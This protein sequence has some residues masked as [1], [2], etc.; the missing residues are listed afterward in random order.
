MLGDIV[1]K[2]GCDGLIS[3]LP[4]LREEHSPDLIIANGENAASGLGITISITRRLLMAG[5]HVITLGNHTWHR[6]EIIP[7][8]DQEPRLLRP[9]NFPAPAP[10]RG[11]GVFTAEDGTQVGVVSLLGRIRLDA[12]EDPFRMADQ[13]LQE[14]ESQGVKTIFFDFHAEATS[15]KQAFGYYLDGRASVVVGT[16]T[17]VQTADEKLLAGGTAY[18]TDVGMT[19]P[20]YSVIGMDP[21]NVIKR[22]I[23]Q[24]PHRFETGGGGAMINGIVAEVDAATGRALSIQRIRMEDL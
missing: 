10:G 21:T 4:A 1:G 2:V 22:F 15:E 19:G 13:I 24:R 18:I 14:L 5:V 17:H 7:Y 9:A 16:H 11:F 6:E 3:A 8:L 23:T 12:V 20:R